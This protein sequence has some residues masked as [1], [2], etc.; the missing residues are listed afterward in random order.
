MNKIY[1]ALAVL[2]ALLS[3]V[4]MLVFPSAAEPVTIKADG[5]N[6]VRGEG[7]LIIYTPDNGA[8]TGTNQWGYEVII[9]NNVAT[10]FSSGGAAIPAN[11]FVLSGH[12]Q[13]EGGKRMGEWIKQN[14]QIGDYVYYNASGIVTVSDEPIE[15]SLYYS[16]ETTFDA[17]NDVRYADTVVIYN[18]IGMLTGTNEWGYEIVCTAGVVTAMGDNNNRVPYD[19]GSF[20]VSAHGAKVEWFQTNVRLGM[21]ASYDKNTKKLV[22]KY[23][24]GS[25]LSGVETLFKNS[26]ALYDTAVDNYSYIDVKA[27]KSGLD[28]IESAIKKA[29]S[30]YEKSKDADAL[31]SACTNI[32]KQIND[33]NHILCESKTVEYRGVW[34]R[35]TQTSASEVDAYVQKLY[36]L[37][38]NTLCI[39]T[40]Y[41]STMIMPMP[42]D[43]L[44]S[45]NP[46]FKHFDMLQSY[47]D[48]C[49][50]RDMELHIW[51]PIYYVGDAGGSNKALSVASKKPEWLSVPNKG[52]PLDN[53]NGFMMLDPANKEASDF[54]LQ[55]YKYILETY[56]IDGFQLD[57]IRYYDR[58]A[59][60]DYGY[61]KT[62]LDEFEEKYGVRP[63]YDTKASYW[64]D[65]VNFRSNYITQFVSRVKKLIGET[66]PDVLLGADVVPDPKDA[67]SKNYQDY[68]TWL[69]NGWLD[70]LFP[71]S[72]GY[73]H[74]NS[75]KAQVDRAGDKAYVAVGLGIF[76]EELTPQIMED[77][78]NY[79]NSV[80]ADGSVYFEASAY[81][82]KKTGE[83]LLKGV[84]RNKAITPALDKAKAAKAKV[85]YTKGRINDVMISLKGISSANA[86]KVVSALDALSAT[87]TD[88]DFSIAKYNAAVDAVNKA[89]LKNAAKKVLLA[90]LAWIIK[91]YSVSNKE[92]DLSD[93][94][95]VP[96]EPIVDPDVSGDT[97]EDTS[98]DT[99]SDASE[100]T[101]NDASEDS[102]NDS[103]SSDE[104]AVVS[105]D[106]SENTE[107]SGDSSVDDENGGNT[108]WIVLGIVAAVAAIAI[109]AVIVIVNLKKGKG[110][111]NA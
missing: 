59:E 46:K 78:A 27:A 47:I 3:V 8:T 106:S 39:E 4:P 95:E 105:G 71:M 11:G 26:K 97:S 41:D 75:I 20:V 6:C 7:Q 88:K 33:L 101:S 111:T 22:F 60:I 40:L 83:C 74:E 103:S 43:S 36:D 58:S 18:E 79:N 35:P 72:Y 62:A 55:S 91:A 14:I 37:G 66:R 63:T 19:K 32:E 104:S 98:E 24:E 94:P 15:E 110:R 25:A 53:S 38:I 69:E 96:D 23:D 57:Y 52:A 49:H 109:I 90:D 81:I 54:L 87:F 16:L 61:S 80:Y 107:A 86:G 67:K 100:D 70:I 77:Q 82:K 73:G 10:K 51:L 64:N 89:D 92:L 21:S 45:T 85:E 99:S 42:K 5:F 34:I 12:D 28:K 44:F 56:D 29:K 68:M 1:R 50:K 13:T 84:Y 93:I 17:I 2:L 30:A 76:M 65:W 31:A 48:S 102:S 108:L 9:E